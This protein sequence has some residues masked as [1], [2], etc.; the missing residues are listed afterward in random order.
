MRPT[1]REHNTALFLLRSFQLGI[2]IEDMKQLTLGMVLDMF[3]EAGNDS[4]E[5]KQ[6]ATQ[7]DFD[8]F[9]GGRF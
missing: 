9:A 6:L 7:A 2:R 1:E 5:Y 8:A 4:V 3:A